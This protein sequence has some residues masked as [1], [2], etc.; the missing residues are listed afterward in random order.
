MNTPKGLEPLTDDGVITAVSRALKSGKELQA[1]LL[2]CGI[3]APFEM[4]RNRL[5]FK[6]H[7]FGA[8]AHDLEALMATTVTGTCVAL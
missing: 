6:S 1:G 4:D 5:T 7:L 3:D 8:G 2:R